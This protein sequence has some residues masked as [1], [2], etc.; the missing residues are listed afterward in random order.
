[1]LNFQKVVLF[2]IEA[3]EDTT[4]QSSEEHGWIKIWNFTMVLLTLIF[5]CVSELIF[6][7]PLV[8]RLK[9]F[10]SKIFRP[11]L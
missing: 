11:V 4:Y 6:D 7:L 10:I 9:I 2:V 3:D 8:I 5:S 1:M